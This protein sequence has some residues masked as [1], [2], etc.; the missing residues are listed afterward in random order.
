MGELLGIG[1]T[2]A[3]HFQY[4]DEHMADIHRMRLKNEKTP[5]AMRDPRNWPPGMQAEWGDDEGLAAARRHRDELVGGFRAARAALDAFRPD[6]VLIWGDDQYENFKEDVVPPYCVYAMDEIPCDLYANTY[7]SY[8][9]TNVFGQPAD[10]R[11]NLPGCREAGNHL[12]RQLILSGFD[13]A[14]S[15]KF[16]HAEVLNHAFVRTVLYLDYDQQGFPYPIIPFHVNCYGSDLMPPDFISDGRT[17]EARDESRQPPP[18]PPPW[19]CY[20]LGKRVAEIIRESPWRAAVIGSSSWS[21]A[22]LTR[23]FPAGHPDVEADRR[24]LDDLRGSQHARWRDVP[25]DT[26]REAGQH[27]FLNWVCLAGAMEGRRADVLAYGET[28]IFNS[29]KCVA[30]FPA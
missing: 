21:H 6:F 15:Y 5:A 20:D 8:A 26:Y 3:P 13:V 18:A 10:L 11:V 22:F 30:L 12:A 19:R 7:A 25:Q 27:E 1:M 23:K 17:V 28:Y 9:K 16:H 4:P 14:Y 24:L 29:D 2:H